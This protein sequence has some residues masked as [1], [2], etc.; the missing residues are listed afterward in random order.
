MA[1]L[2]S[3][4][5]HSKFQ[6]EEVLTIQTRR[7]VSAA[8]RTAHRPLS[9]PDLALHT[10]AECCHS[11]WF[12]PSWVGGPTLALG[13]SQSSPM[14]LRE[15][16]W[17]PFEL[18]EAWQVL[19]VLEDLAWLWYQWGDLDGRCLLLVVRSFMRGILTRWEVK[20]SLQ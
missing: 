5:I 1:Q 3:F 14:W 13:S 4:L 15:E 2:L 8:D 7:L 17:A 18:G 11:Q 19:G 16:K 20:P 6:K 12:I 9:G 10:Q